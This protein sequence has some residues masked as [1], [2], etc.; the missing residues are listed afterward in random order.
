MTLKMMAL[1]LL[2]LLVARRLLVAGHW[3]LLLLL[4]R[5][6]LVA[7]HWLL[8]LLVARRLLV[9]GHWLLLLLVARGLL[10]AGHWL[11]LLLVAR[12][13]LVAGHWL[14]L[15]VAR[16]L[17]VAG[18]WLLLQAAARARRLQKVTARPRLLLLLLDL[19]LVWHCRTRCWHCCVVKRGCCCTWCCC[20][21]AEADA[22][23]SCRAC[24]AWVNCRRLLHL[25]LLRPDLLLLLVPWPLCRL[26]TP[27]LLVHRTIVIRTAGSHI[28]VTR[29]ITHMP[30][31]LLY[32]LLLLLPLQL[33]Q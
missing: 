6:L 10:V 24:C 33:P 27:P 8:L 11:L 1:P 15:L 3:L 19:K 13:L 16:R 29:V 25:L 17:L 22:A 7:G 4:A 18:H 30:S 5:G 32:L 12:R 23:G 9:A 2:L 31:L 28:H 21:V 14:L 20:D 26:L